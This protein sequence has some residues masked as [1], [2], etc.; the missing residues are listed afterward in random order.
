MR[1]INALQI[2]RLSAQPANSPLVRLEGTAP[3]RASMKIDKAVLC[4]PSSRQDHPSHWNVALNAQVDA[5]NSLRIT[6]NRND[7]VGEPW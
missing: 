7:L 5:E 2:N 6:P 3:A 4:A 1:S